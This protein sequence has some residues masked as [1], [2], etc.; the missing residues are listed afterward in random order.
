MEPNRNT[1]TSKL[2]RSYLSPLCPCGSS[3]EIVR[4]TR[5]FREGGCGHPSKWKPLRDAVLVTL[6]LVLW[7]LIYYAL[8]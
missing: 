5:R 3:V 7:R 4:E 8:K 1:R 6:Y 2:C